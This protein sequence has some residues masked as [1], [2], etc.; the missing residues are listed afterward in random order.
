MW[1][2]QQKPTKDGRDRCIRKLIG[3]INTCCG[4]GEIDKAYIQFLDKTCVRG[5]DA[6]III[7]ILKK[8]SEVRENK[9]EWL[10]ELF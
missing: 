8:W 4:H 3:L 7:E 2:L 9:E 5:N 6:V 10:K 1:A